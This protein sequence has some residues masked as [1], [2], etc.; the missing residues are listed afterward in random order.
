MLGTSK[1][2]NPRFTPR[3]AMPPPDRLSGWLVLAPAAPGA[4]NLVGN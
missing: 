3:D 4:K 1:V 2:P